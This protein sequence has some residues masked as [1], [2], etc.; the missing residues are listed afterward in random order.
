MLSNPSTWPSCGSTSVAF[1]ST[2]ASAF[3]DATY[4]VRF[5]RWIGTRLA[6]GP[7]AWVS[8]VFSIQPTNESTSFCIG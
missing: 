7:F 8:S 4:S 2:P 5:R 3:T 6:F 1:K